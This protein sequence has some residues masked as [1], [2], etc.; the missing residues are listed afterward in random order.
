MIGFES[1]GRGSRMREPLLFDMDELVEDLYQQV[2]PHVDAQDYAIYGHSMGGLASYLLTTRL[3]KEK[4]RLPQQLFITGTTGPSAVSRQE[5]KR[6]L[7]E[8]EEFISEI[9][10]L[11]GM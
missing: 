4:H 5:K 6:Y 8:K 9:R 11:D 10:D 1:P 7:L 2:K 3:I